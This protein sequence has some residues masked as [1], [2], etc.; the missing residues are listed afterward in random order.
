MKNNVGIIIVSYNAPQAVAMTLEALADTPV[1]TPFSVALIDNT[2]SSEPRAAIA[3]CIEMHLEKGSFPGRF[4]PLKDNKG[5]SGGNN[6][7]LAYFL[8]QPQ[9]TH[10]CLLNSDVVVSDYWLDYLLE[11]GHE[12]VG[13]LTNAS[14]N[15]QGIPVP[16]AISKENGILHFD[17][18]AYLDFAARRRKLWRGF[19]R[20]SE[21]ISFFCTIL[22]RRLVQQVGYMDTRFYPGAYEDDDYCARILESGF[23][24]YVRRD[25]F[26]HHWG[27]ASFEKL[28]MPDRQ[29]HGA[30]NRKRFVEKYRHSWRDR[31][32]LSWRAWLHD[33]EYALSKASPDV[34]LPTLQLYR[35]RLLEFAKALDKR[36]AHLTSSLK[37]PE[38]SAHATLEYAFLALGT[39]LQKLVLSAPV[40][41]RELKLFTVEGNKLEQY[42]C[43]HMTEVAEMLEK[44]ESCPDADLS[45]MGQ[46]VRN[47]YLSED[48]WTFLQSLEKGI[49]F[50]AGYPF[51]ERLN[52]GYFQRVKAID[53]LVPKEYY[54]VYC[55]ASP[56]F[57]GEKT[58][59]RLSENT[60]LLQVNPENL[61]HQLLVSNC[62]QRFKKI[63]YHS[64]LRMLYPI[65]NMWLN[66]RDIYKILDVHGVVPEEFIYC[67][68]DYAS[69]ALYSDIE[70]R[71]VRQCDS[72]IVVSD[73]M[74]KHLN[75][76]YA[77]DFTKKIIT[78]P[79]FPSF[80]SDSG[81]QPSTKSCARPKLVYA[82]GTHPWQCLPRMIKAIECIIEK[83]EV[84]I[85][86]TVPQDVE[87]MV[88]K[89]LL[90][91]PNFLLGSVT[92]E[93]LCH[94]YPAYDYGFLLREDVTVNRVACPTKL[95][96]YL[97]YG[98]VPV[99]NSKY[100]GD[101]NTLGM[102]YISV[103]EIEQGKFLPYD[104]HEAYA[105]HNL[106]IL[107][108]L[109]KRSEDNMLRLKA[110]LMDG[111]A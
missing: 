11:G 17:K 35:N 9:I 15:E 90:M 76:K 58:I 79:I 77:S 6:I 53:E 103:E 46:D 29:N 47:P 33:A 57:S 31:T 106:N 55:D 39:Q 13:P 107:K 74:G 109:K 75:Q 24:M 59:R 4:F 45:I 83:A 95:V 97:A 60:I 7:G 73:T 34:F 2:P 104:R 105:R 93:E 14:N 12:A 98:I 26:L 32:H 10:L 91:H 23:S 56:D 71:A 101:F 111:S 21:F 62:V 64:V 94:R 102:K 85:F 43:A 99:L 51:P 44:V 69:S 96:E 81:T 63:Y 16:Y 48:L 8:A 86:T 3:S 25:V 38:K 61:T 70:S 110:I 41:E 67:S 84:D 65:Q 87:R 88:P 82:G 36:Y 50:F 89:E 18:G 42:I 54:R 92:H 66:E 19:V 100:I 22:S 40:R 28:E 27:S 5:F 80:K 30:R 37:R 1:G 68:D 52:D 108:R 78:I 20:R 72:I 49:V